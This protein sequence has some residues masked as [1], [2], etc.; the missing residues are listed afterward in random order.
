M[1]LIFYFYFILIR[2]HDI[3]LGILTRKSL[4]QDESVPLL[5]ISVRF[6]PLFILVDFDDFSCRFHKQFLN[7]FYIT[8][9]ALI[10]GK[11][12]LMIYIVVGGGIVHR[13]LRVKKKLKVQ[14][15]VRVFKRF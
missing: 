8:L 4:N 2:E 10:Y 5:F 9:K 14:I 6:S 15:F 12:H 13:E 1:R 7:K 3:C 11:E